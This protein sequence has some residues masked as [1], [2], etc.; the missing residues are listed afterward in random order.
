MFNCFRKGGWYGW[1]PSSSPNFSIRV[2]RVYPL[3][4]SNQ[5]APCRAIRGNSIPVNSTLPLSLCTI[6]RRTSPRLPS[7]G[8]AHDRCAA[9][10]P[11]EGVGKT[12][13]TLRYTSA[14]CCEL[15]CRSL[16]FYFDI[17]ITVHNSVQA[18][19]IEVIVRNSFRALLSFA[20][21]RDELGRYVSY[22]YC[23]YCCYYE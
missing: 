1:K 19:N 16:V 8:E 7:R 9:V 6:C 18:L 14:M 10:P 20:G 3:I 15:S 2:F 17:E 21:L 13:A 12:H 23:Y 11:R 5:T 22:H 4:E